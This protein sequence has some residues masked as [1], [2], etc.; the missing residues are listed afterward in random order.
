MGERSLPVGAQGHNSPRDPDFPVF[1]GIKIINVRKFIND[2]LCQM[3]T[4]KTLPKR[5]NPC[6]AQFFHFSPPVFHF[7]GPNR[8]FPLLIFHFPYPLFPVVIPA[9]YLSSRP[10]N[11]ELRP[12]PKFPVFRRLFSPAKPG[13]L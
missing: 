5:I 2:L 12:E 11:A 6:T 1:T 3:G 7:S 8:C 10:G 9:T 13:P 4:G